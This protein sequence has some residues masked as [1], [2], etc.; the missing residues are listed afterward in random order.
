MKQIKNKM[1]DKCCNHSTLDEIKHQLGDI[2]S[3]SEWINECVNAV[4]Q[5]LNEMEEPFN[6]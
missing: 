5:T 1:I 6:G 2:K 4:E 3:Y